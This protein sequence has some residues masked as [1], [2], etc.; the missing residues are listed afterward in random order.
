VTENRLFAIMTLA[1]NLTIAEITKARRYE[2]TKK[3][4]IITSGPADH[5]SGQRVDVRGQTR[6]S[7]PD[8]KTSCKERRSD[9]EALDELGADSGADLALAVEDVGKRRYGDAR[10]SG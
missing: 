5:R 4:E 8:E 1:R 2:S 7:S 6:G 3:L 9:A 10:A